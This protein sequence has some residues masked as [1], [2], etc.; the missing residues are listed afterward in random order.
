MFCE[1]SGSREVGLQQHDEC[2]DVVLGAALKGLAA[3][4][5]GRRLHAAV[6]LREHRRD[7]VDRLAVGEHIPHAC[8]ALG[9]GLGL[10]VGLGLGSATQ[11]Q[12]VPITYG[13]RELHLLR[14]Y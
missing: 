11:R 9:L 4:L 1:V 7:D 8:L 14:P 13:Y 2:G 12:H 6:G 3:Q 5:L 10:G